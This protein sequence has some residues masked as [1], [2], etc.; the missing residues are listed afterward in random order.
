MSLNCPPPAS[1]SVT[2]SN[3]TGPACDTAIDMSCDFARLKKIPPS[4]NTNY[5]QLASQSVHLIEAFEM[6]AMR[7]RVPQKFNRVICARDTDGNVHEGY[8]L[9]EMRQLL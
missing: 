7:H 9:A 4:Q 3:M 5:A 1:L 8:L 2:S 6:K